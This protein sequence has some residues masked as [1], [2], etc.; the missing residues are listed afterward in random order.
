MS[1]HELHYHNNNGLD[2][3]LIFQLLF[4]FTIFSLNGQIFNFDGHFRELCGILRMK[5]LF[6]DF[7]NFHPTNKEEQR[8]KR[9]YMGFWQQLCGI[10]ILGLQR[11]RRTRKEGFASNNRGKAYKMRFLKWND[12]FALSHVKNTCHFV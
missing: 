8:T 1:S 6:G 10:V 5:K 2:D 12:P 3:S 11:E 7:T 4:A 9:N